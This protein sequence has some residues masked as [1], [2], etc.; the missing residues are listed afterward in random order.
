MRLFA[1]LRLILLVAV[2]ICGFHYLFTA[3]GNRNSR[4]LRPVCSKTVTNRVDVGILKR[5]PRHSLAQ[6][7]L[8][9][10]SKPLN[11]LFIQTV[12]APLATVCDAEVVFVVN[13][14]P[15]NY[16]ERE[17]LRRNVFTENI[18]LTRRISVFFVIGMSGEPHL[19][20][21][22]STEANRK[23]D[24]LLVN[25][26]ENYHNITHKARAWITFLHDTCESP[27][28]KF[29]TKIDDDIML[30][31]PGFL[32][33]LHEFHA[34]KRVVLG[35]VYTNGPVMRHPASKWYLSKKEYASNGL[36]L[37]LQGMAYTFSFDLING[38]YD[39][40]KRVQYL[41]MDDWYVTHALM[42][43]LTAIYFDLSKHYLSLDSEAEVANRLK[44]AKLLSRKLL[45]GHFR[46][47]SAFP[48]DRRQAAW[49]KLRLA[50][51]S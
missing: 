13:S 32:N 22:V 24:I 26:L 12:L 9:I 1:L 28:P 36:G 11:W 34:F 25:V 38:M 14:E 39:N 18:K 42:K 19:D 20:T 3:I 49:E 4:N 21:K 2:L 8:P 44:R 23:E 47:K 10:A 48:A 30:D 17:N 51:C 27:A 43:D 35:R 6:Y 7:N 15:G 29:V 31:L 37:Y 33:L 45:F 5:Y 40:L 16:A 46:P 50:S 41:W